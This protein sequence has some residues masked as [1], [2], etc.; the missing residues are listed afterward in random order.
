M[1]LYYNSFTG[2]DIAQLGERL[3]RNQKVRG[4]IPLIST[5]KRARS[6]VGEHL[7][8]IQEV[9]GSKPAAP[10]KNI[11]D[12][13]KKNYYT[14]KCLWVILCKLGELAQLGERLNGIQEVRGSTPLFSTKMKL[15][16]R[17]ERRCYVF[18]F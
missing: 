16:R 15:R 18:F 10:T 1:A 14:S 12:N 11:L 8:H 13:I 3:V 2:G 5:N 4:S 7:T 9:A 6:S 17:A